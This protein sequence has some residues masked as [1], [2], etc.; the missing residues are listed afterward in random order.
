MDADWTGT[1]FEAAVD[2]ADGTPWPRD[3]PGGTDWWW[4]SQNR[5]LGLGLRLLGLSVDIDQDVRHRITE[6]LGVPMLAVHEAMGTIEAA[7]GYRSRGAAIL[8]V[9]NRIA[10]AVVRAVM[11]AGHLAG[12]WGPPLWWEGVLRPLYRGSGTDPP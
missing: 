10:G 12:V 3:A 8:E 7:P 9:L 11:V 1:V 5:M 2:A 4:S 6:E